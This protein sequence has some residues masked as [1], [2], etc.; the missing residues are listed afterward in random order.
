MILQSTTVGDLPYF[1]H[2]DNIFILIQWR[3]QRFPGDEC[4]FANDIYNLLNF[5]YASLK[6]NPH[7]DFLFP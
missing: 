5:V 2:N 4:F 1:S 3:Q 7:T 6:P